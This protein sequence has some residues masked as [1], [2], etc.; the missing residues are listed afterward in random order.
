MAAIVDQLMQKINGEPVKKL[1]EQLGSD[2]EKTRSALGSAIPFLL[3]SMARKSHDGGEGAMIRDRISA[4]KDSGFDLSD[5]SSFFQNSSGSQGLLNQ[6]LG[7]NKNQV[8]QYI[9]RDSGLEQSKVSQLLQ[10]A[11]P[12]VTKFLANREKEEQGDA[13]D[14]L[15]RFDEDMKQNNP[16]SHGVLNRLLDRDGDGD[17]KDD[18][19]EMGK[20]LFNNFTGSR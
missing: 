2:E 10:M 9:Q 20:S 5:L 17:I 16:Q 13:M 19:A 12:L 7:N 4:E 3:Q 1:S 6:L 15:N 14:Q 8:E 18:V 11:A